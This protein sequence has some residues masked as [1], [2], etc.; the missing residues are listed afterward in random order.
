[1]GV[2]LDW[3]IESERV[4]E[5]VGEDPGERRRRYQKRFRLILTTLI[6]FGLVGLLGLLIAFR[7]FTVDNKLRQ[8]LTDVVQTETAALRI[9]DYAG[10]MALQRSPSESW[11]KGQSALY[12]RYQE[13]KTTAH[14]QLTGNVLD[15]TI[16]SVS[17]SIRGRVLVEEI[18]EGVPYQTIW[19]YWHY[20]DDGW[21]HVPSDYTFWGDSATLTGKVSTVNYRQLDSRFAGALAARVD[22]WWAESCADLGCQA[23]KK[24][25]V[26]IV[27]SPTARIHWDTS[28]TLIVPSPLASEER[29]RSDVDIEPSVEDAVATLI[30]EHVVDA[31]TNNLKPVAVTDASWLRQAT[32]EWLAASFT[33][34]GDKTRLGFIQSIKDNYGMTALATL[35]HSLTADAD[36]RIVATA[37]GQP[38]EMLMLD[39][40]A[41]FQWRLDVEKTLLARNDQAGVIA[42]WDTANPAAYALMQQRMA[43]PLQPTG[44]VQAVAIAAGADG[45]PRA[46]IQITIDGSPQVIVFRLVDG[47]WKHSG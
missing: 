21:R 43:N 45:V 28:D 6:I 27:P 19:F 4:Y 20:S 39:W 44:Q 17:N 15:V 7:L 3:Q 11:I 47:T 30:A 10:Y 16:D 25:T 33:G 42:L 29:T 18:L 13:L 22:R 1:L 23:S 36:I 35:L 31:V 9:G 5:R 32:I 24:L 2:K 38:L 26:N 41:F 12:A 8:D 46:T 37:L 34:R 14:L 40:R